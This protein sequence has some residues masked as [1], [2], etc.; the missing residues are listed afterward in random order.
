MD[1]GYLDFLLLAHIDASRA[2]LVTRAKSNTSFYV[3]ASRPVGKAS[4]LRA[5]QI[6]RLNGSKTKAHY[7]ENLRRIS[8]LDTETGKTLVFLTNDFEVEA[9]IVA[10]IYKARWQIELF[11]KWLNQNLRIKAFYGTSE[12]AVKTQIWIA[13]SAYLLVAILNKTLGIEQSM[14]RVLHVISVNV[15]SKN[16]IHQLLTDCNTSEAL[17]NTPTQFIFNGF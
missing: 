11:F 9:T 6:I 5:D 3:R 7:L 17:N 13:M 12:N 15:F 14:S 10:K 16:T 2:F 4:G 8:Y 1:R